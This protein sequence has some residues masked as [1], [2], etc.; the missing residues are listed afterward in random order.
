M[1]LLIKVLEHHFWQFRWLFFFLSQS[2][3]V[4]SSDKTQQVKNLSAKVFLFAVLHKVIWVAQSWRELM[5]KCWERNWPPV[6]PET[7]WEW[8]RTCQRRPRVAKQWTLAWNRSTFQSI[9]QL[10]LTIADLFQLFKEAGHSGISFFLTECMIKGEWAKKLS[11]TEDSIISLDLLI[12]F[13]RPCWHCWHL[14]LKE[15]FTCTARKTWSGS[16]SDWFCRWWWCTRCRNRSERTKSSDWF[17]P[18]MS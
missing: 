9:F 5:R 16:I 8:C 14:Y 15:V 1:T 4:A 13:I 18:A 10:K 17:R 11:Y 12:C 2:C 3:F 6:R 7:S